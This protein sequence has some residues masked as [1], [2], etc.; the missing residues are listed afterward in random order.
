M[1]EDVSFI[2]AFTDYP[3]LLPLCANNDGKRF[4]GAHFS[5][6]FGMSELFTQID[7]TNADACSIF[8]S[9]SRTWNVS[10]PT[11]LSSYEA[12]R[13]SAL[14]RNLDRRAF[15]P[16]AP[17][18]VNLASEKSASYNRSIN[19]MI[20]EA[21]CTRLLGLTLLNVHP[22]SAT[23]YEPS[24]RDSALR[25]VSNAINRI[26]STVPDVVIVLETTAGCKSGTIIG[27]RFE[28]LRDIIGRIDQKGRVGVC[29]DTQHVF[30]GGFGYSDSIPLPSIAPDRA[31][32]SVKGHAQWICS[33]L[34]DFERVVGLQYLRGFH[35]NNSMTLYGSKVDRHASI[36]SG[37]IPLE[38]YR[39]LLQDPRTKGV[40]FILETPDSQLWKREISLLRGLEGLKGLGRAS[41]TQS[42]S[43]DK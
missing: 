18:L 42:P 25:K 37:F 20:Y 39:A 24:D 36:E 14:K 12:F 21:F 17:Y 35:V 5:R 11:D 8:V 40:C 19:R 34:D 13:A 7:T 15:L 10:I 6:A 4:I 38:E 26:L 23:G 31:N 9:N 32:P 2:Q 29:I 22:G 41:A 30:A 43:E 16:H 1:Q 28:E 27:N 33:V 3:S